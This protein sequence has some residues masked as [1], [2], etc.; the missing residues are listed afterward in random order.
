[1]PLVHLP[2]MNLP[3]LTH[4]ESSNV[5]FLGVSEFLSN[6]FR[7][8]ADNCGH[9]AIPIRRVYFEG[10]CWKTCI[11]AAYSA[12]GLWS[13]VRNWLRHLREHMLPTD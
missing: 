3:G 1:M 13:A 2:S 6:S 12:I 4:G 9:G 5:A 8:Y 10:P 7:L 11:H